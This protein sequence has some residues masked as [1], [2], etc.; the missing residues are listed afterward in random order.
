MNPGE[1][2]SFPGGPFAPK[3]GWLF[4]GDEI[5]ADTGGDYASL[6]WDGFEIDRVYCDGR[7]AIHN[8]IP[9]SF[10][11]DGEGEIVI[12]ITIP[13]GSE[14]AVELNAGWNLVTAGAND[15]V[16][17]DAI[18]GKETIVTGIYLWDAVKLQWGR[19]IPGAPATVNTI[20]KFEKGK[21]YWVQV[22]QPFTLMLLR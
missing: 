14:K 3:L 13:F 9:A 2:I 17:A 19:Y 20:S 22:N 10:P 5:F 4:S 16:I 11:L 12:D 6:V 8:V 18:S 1:S 7:P 15:T 21:I